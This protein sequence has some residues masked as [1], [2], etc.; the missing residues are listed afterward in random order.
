MHETVFRRDGQ[1]RLIRREDSRARWIGMG[2]AVSIVHE[3]ASL[4]RF[5]LAK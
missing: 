3:Y 1:G 2:R 5:T 4:K